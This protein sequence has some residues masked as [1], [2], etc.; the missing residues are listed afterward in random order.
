MFHFE[1]W[2]KVAVDIEREGKVG[3]RNVRHYAKLDNVIMNVFGRRHGFRVRENQE[4]GGAV[5]ELEFL[6]KEGYELL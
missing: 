2:E 5:D 4:N 3:V 1:E 6:V